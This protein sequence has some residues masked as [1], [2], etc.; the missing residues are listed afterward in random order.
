MQTP[1]VGKD[2]TEAQHFKL[3]WHLNLAVPY[4]I[5]LKERYTK[6]IFVHQNST[7]VT[8]MRHTG[9]NEKPKNITF[10]F[11]GMQNRVHCV[12][13]IHWDNYFCCCNFVLIITI[14]CTMLC[15]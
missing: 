1:G 8:S 13:C 11:C 7:K 15:D 12:N 5:L 9:F 2:E 6:A 3:N 14:F 4:T 10:K